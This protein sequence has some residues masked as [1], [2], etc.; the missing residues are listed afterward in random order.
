MIPVHD[1]YI[2]K[3]LKYITIQDHLATQHKYAADWNP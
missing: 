2:G 3:G 1:R